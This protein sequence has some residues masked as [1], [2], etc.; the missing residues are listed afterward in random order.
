M[1]NKT[2]DS[3]ELNTTETESLNAN[4]HKKKSW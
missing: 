2:D 3:S 4:K 1:E